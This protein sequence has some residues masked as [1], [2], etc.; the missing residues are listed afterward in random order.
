MDSLLARLEADELQVLARAA[1]AVAMLHD[2]PD[3]DAEE[4]DEKESM[5]VSFHDISEAKCKA[6]TGFSIAEFQ[7]I[8]RVLA[9]AL[10][11]RANG[12]AGR[13]PEKMARPD[14]RLLLFLT[15]IKTGYSYKTLGAFFGIS[16]PYCM[17]LIAY[18]LNLAFPIVKRRWIPFMDHKAQEDA[19]ILLPD[20][21]ECA[22]II[23]VTCHRILRPSGQHQRFYSGH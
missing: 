3:D 23:D 1:E 21:P 12:R 8:N 9:T 6:L 5:F 14:D 17:E 13:R 15:W 19:E 4:Q 16:G 7:Q 18:I 2:R 22:A 20:F 10:I 11:P